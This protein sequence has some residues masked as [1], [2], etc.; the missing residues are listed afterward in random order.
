MRG[1]ERGWRVNPRALASCGNLSHVVYPLIHRLKTTV[2]WGVGPGAE[3]KFR[4]KQRRRFDRETRNKIIANLRFR[5]KCRNEGSYPHAPSTGVDKGS[6]Y[7]PLLTGL[8]TGAGAGSIVGACAALRGGSFR[9]GAF[10]I[11]YEADFSAAQPATEARARLY[12]TYEH[13]R[14]AVA[15]LATPPQKG[16]SSPHRLM[17][18]LRISLRRAGEFAFLRRRGGPSAYWGNRKHLTIGLFKAP[19]Q[20]GDALSGVGITVRQRRSARP[21][22][23]NGSGPPQDRRRFL[24]TRRLEGSERPSAFLLLRAPKRRG[25]PFTDAARAKL[26]KAFVA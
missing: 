15:S 19:A 1:R 22:F 14:M 25:A 6:L 18:R 24:P 2:Y 11:R 9:L 12:G 20:A 3:R 4:G 5:F 8:L 23:R 26:N 17:A 16:A 21:S 10:S 13:Q 7:H